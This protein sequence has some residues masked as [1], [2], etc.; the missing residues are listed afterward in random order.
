MPAWQS[1]AGVPPHAGS[2]GTGRGV[3][4][5]A[6]DTDPAGDADPATGYQVLVDGKAMVIGGTS[7]VAPLLA[8]LVCRLTQGLGRRLGLLQPAIYADAPA[9]TTPPGFRDITSGRNGAYTAGPGW[10]ACTGLG[11][12]NG[13]QL[14]DRLRS[15]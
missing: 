10:D 4:D 13:Q 1:G 2:G 3:P 5:V 8:A 6:G 7:A 11:V 14:L 9:G 15:G 12:P